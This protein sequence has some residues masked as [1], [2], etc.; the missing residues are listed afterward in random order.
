MK[1]PM[2]Q[3]RNS[4]LIALLSMLVFISSF[5]QEAKKVVTTRTQTEHTTFWGSP[6]MWAL[7]AAI[8][9]LL[10]AAILRGGNRKAEA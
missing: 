10:L 6:W 8:F 5:A 2:K 4:T 9:I 7:G 1:T 3:I